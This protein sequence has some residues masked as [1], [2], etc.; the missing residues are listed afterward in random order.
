MGQESI[1]PLYIA[2]WLRSRRPVLCSSLLATVTHLASWIGGCCAPISG[3]GSQCTF[4]ARY[5]DCQASCKGCPIKTATAFH[6]PSRFMP[7][8]RIS[9]CSRSWQ[10]QNIYR[11]KSQMSISFLT[12]ILACKHHS[13]GQTYLHL[14]SQ[15]DQHDHGDMGRREEEDLSFVL[16]HLGSQ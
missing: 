13:L 2:L 15:L 3:E 9:S 10:N 5:S 16:L 12:T 14:L 11:F 7:Y 1:A 4:H 8:T 6:L